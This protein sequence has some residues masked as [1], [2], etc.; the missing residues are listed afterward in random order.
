MHSPA[1]HYQI[2][3][4]SIEQ[5]ILAGRIQA[6][7]KLP[8]ERQLA[9]TFATTRVTLR[10]ALALLEG[11]GLIYR[12]NRR[13]WYVSPPRLRYNPTERASFNELVTAQG[14]LGHTK[15]LSCQLAYP[16]PEAAQT[17]GLPAFTKSWNLQRLRSLDG[18]VVLLEENHVCASC[19]P[20]LGRHDLSQSL[21]RLFEEHYQ[22][23]LARTQI[24]FYPV[25]LEGERASLLGLTPGS[26]ALFIRR[27]NFDEAGRLYELDHEYWRHDALVIELE[28]ISAPPARQP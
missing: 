21:T 20:D 9:D 27:L 28:R 14:R 25:I 5:E 1:L 26:S 16:A 8:A 7:G 3:S 11:K 4:Q 17:M 12:E 18:R 24:Q 22:L 23:H 15:L 10:E 6:Q 2:I 19:C 13:G